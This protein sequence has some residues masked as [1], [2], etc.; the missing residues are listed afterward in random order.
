MSSTSDKIKSKRAEILDGLSSLSDQT[1]EKA[2]PYYSP[3]FIRETLTEAAKLFRDSVQQQADPLQE[4]DDIDNSAVSGSTLYLYTDGA[5]RGNPG[6]GGAGVVITDSMGIVHRRRRIISQQN[7]TQV[8][9]G[10]GR[11]TPEKLNP[12]NP[13]TISD[14]SRAQS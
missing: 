10:T 2:F 1:L 12:D 11:R 5:S 4:Q 8:F 3:A 6:Q 7:A 14:G 9:V 13:V